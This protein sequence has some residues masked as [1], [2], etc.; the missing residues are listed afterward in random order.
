MWA[1]SGRGER[2]AFTCDR[3]VIEE[4]IELHTLCVVANT[5]WPSLLYTLT[6]IIMKIYI[7]TKTHT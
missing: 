7:H 1:R 5:A 6:C 3:H 4:A 2:K